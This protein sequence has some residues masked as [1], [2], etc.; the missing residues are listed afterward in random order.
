MNTKHKQQGS[1]SS[2]L[3]TCRL[4]LEVHFARLGIGVTS[5]CFLN[6]SEGAEK[7][8]ENGRDKVL[9]PRKDR[10]TRMGNVGVLYSPAKIQ[11]DWGQTKLATR[12]SQ[13]S[14]N[15]N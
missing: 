11:T 2:P 12:H 10:G 15:R 8:R 1:R 4:A 5:K 13:Q 7:K 14:T 9:E 3:P 6:C